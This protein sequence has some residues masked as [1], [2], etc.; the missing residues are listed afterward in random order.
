MPCFVWTR[1]AQPHDEFLDLEPVD[2]V[3]D[4]YN[5]AGESS[6]VDGVFSWVEFGP[7]HDRDGIDTTCGAGVDGVGKSVTMDDYFEDHSGIYLRLHSI[8]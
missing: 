2:E 3:H 7:E 6:Y 8:E 1:T 5:A 4:H